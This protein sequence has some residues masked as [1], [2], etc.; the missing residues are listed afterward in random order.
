MEHGSSQGQIV[1]DFGVY[2]NC[3]LCFG[4]KH[5]WRWENS[6]TK[7]QEVDWGFK[8]WR[9]TT[10]D[11]DQVILGYDRLPWF[12][13]ATFSNSNFSHPHFLVGVMQKI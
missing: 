6:A 9:K 8:T 11:N 1:S 2:S 5:L 7:L 4:G 12:V 10:N 13:V 3:Y